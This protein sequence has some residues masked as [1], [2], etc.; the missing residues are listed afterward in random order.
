MRGFTSV[1]E[2]L[3]PQALID[4]LNLYFGCQ[5]PAVLSHGGEVLNPGMCSAHSTVVLGTD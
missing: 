3:P 5:V 1:S 4:R 2:R